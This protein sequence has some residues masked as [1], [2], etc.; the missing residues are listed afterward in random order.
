MTPEAYSQTCSTSGITA[1]CAITGSGSY[2]L[3]S[4]INTTASGDCISVVAAGVTLEGQGF[5]I[6]NTDKVPTGTGIH[7]LKSAKG[8]L[9]NAGSDFATK[10]QVNGFATDI[11]NDAS[12]VRIEQV[13][14]INATT[15]IVNNGANAS[16]YSLQDYGNGTGFVNNGALGLTLGY[17]A[18]DANGV[19]LVLNNTTAAAAFS[20][21]N[22]FNTSDGIEINGGGKNTFYS[23]T[24]IF[25][26]G[27]GVVVSKSNN[28]QF[29]AFQANN[30]AKDGIILK[31]SSGNS[32]VAIQANANGEAGVYV[33]CSS[34][35]IPDGTTCGKSKSNLNSLV[36]G[37]SSPTTA[38]DNNKI[39]VGI[40][41]GNSNNQV[42]EVEGSGNKVKDA[43]DNN[44]NC[45]KD[46]W[47]L[48]SF[49]SVTPSCVH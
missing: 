14:V 20:C 38:D 34:A 25:N 32:L 29:V 1:C 23:C 41:A 16:Y 11:Q 44:A 13:T 35:G 47:A 18:A 36:G 4:D 22:D 46:L 45:D 28:N 5:N 8:F 48:N 19:G 3:T 33:G 10:G 43:V 26:G 15:G 31:S 2:K 17:Y 30:S 6:E 21:G 24:A 42:A 9:F 39:G 37:G 27:S 7:A 49:N 12:R 40:D